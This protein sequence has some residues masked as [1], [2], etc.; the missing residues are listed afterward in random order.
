MEAIAGARKRV[1]CTRNRNTGF[2]WGSEDWLSDGEMSPGPCG[3][4]TED[5]IESIGCT[6]TDP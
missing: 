3:G 2:Q 5:P 4:D 6:G 1:R